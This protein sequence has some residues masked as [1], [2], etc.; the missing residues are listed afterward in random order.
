M[1]TALTIPSLRHL[2]FEDVSRMI[3]AEMQLR[4]SVLGWVGKENS[5]ALK[6][7][8]QDYVDVVEKHI[9]Q[10]ELFCREE[11]LAACI[12]NNRVMSALIADADDRLSACTCSAV[13]DVCLLSAI[14]G[15]NH[16][17]INVYGTVAAF[18]GTVRLE[19]AGLMFHQAEA[20]EKEM[21]ERL[22]YLA[23][24]DLNRKAAAPVTV[25]E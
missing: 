20:D 8:M 5:G 19:K 6:M 2:L 21:D 3:S 12:L 10:L 14:Q 11:R 4:S 25:T 13:R 7:L 15:I 18:A 23:E 24:H 9:R 22:S 17:K 16:F 1:E